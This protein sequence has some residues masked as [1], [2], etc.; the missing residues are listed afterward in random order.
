MFKSKG[1]FISYCIEACNNNSFV[2]AKHHP[3]GMSIPWNVDRSINSWGNPEMA[4]FLASGDFKVYV[5]SDSNPKH[6]PELYVV[7]PNDSSIVAGS[8]VPKLSLT[9][10]TANDVF[11]VPSGVQQGWHGYSYASAKIKFRE[12][13]NGTD[14]LTFISELL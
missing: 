3:S 2:T 10:T 7:E 6:S 11:A 8:G 12:A 1:E 9:A 14:K 13:S 5:Y 4:S